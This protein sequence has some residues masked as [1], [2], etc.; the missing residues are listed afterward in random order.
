[1]SKHEYSH[2]SS[3]RGIV[4]WNRGFDWRPDPRAKSTV[5]P[6]AVLA[7]RLDAPPRG[8][9]AGPGFA[10]WRWSGR[11]GDVE[12]WRAWSTTIIFAQDVE[13]GMHAR[14]CPR[15]SPAPIAA[16]AWAAVERQYV[17]VWDGDAADGRG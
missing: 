1:M 8:Y 9:A 17:C 16:R 4:S 12:A 2:D 13:V 14:A 3:T 10:L 15:S 6:Q 11:R 7:A 5:S